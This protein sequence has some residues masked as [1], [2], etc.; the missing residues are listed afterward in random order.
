MCLLYSGPT[1]N[2]GVL[3]MA[4]LKTFRELNVYMRAMAASRRIFYLSQHWPRV[5]R[6]A[7]TNQIRRSSR[8]VSAL[9]AEGW[10]RRR[11][12][13]AFVNKINEALGE[14]YETRTWIEH[15]YECGYIE[16]DLKVELDAEWNAIGGMLQR[17]ID[18]SA[19]FSPIKSGNGT[20]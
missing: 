8:A 2:L 10:A 15:A 9:V 20:A 5:E 4:Q 3:D 7:L 13:P 6:Y 12:T 18:R 17:M 1:N 11:Y 19:E 14:A 16:T